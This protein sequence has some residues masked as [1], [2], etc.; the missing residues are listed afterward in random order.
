[1]LMLSVFTALATGACSKDTTDGTAGPPGTEAG[2]D[3]DG[4]DPDAAA[5]DSAAEEDGA[6]APGTDAGIVDGPG[7]VGALC[8]FNR[9]CQAALRCECDE[10]AGCA[11]KTGTRGTGKKGVDSCTT[12]NTCASAVCVEGPPDSGFFC[13]DECDSSAECVGKLP[14]CSTI[15]F[16]GRIC[17][18]QN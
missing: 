8:S 16:V 4:G 13:S 9:D 12:G 5:A 7:K 6:I 15:A 11:C 18:R 17:I 3:P 14:L 2:S 10:T 1:M